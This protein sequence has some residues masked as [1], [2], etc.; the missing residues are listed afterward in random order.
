MIRGKKRGPL[1]SIF[2]FI[3]LIISF[4]NWLFIMFRNGLYRLRLLPR[5]RLEVP[6]I[7]IGNIT[8]GGT[9]KTPLVRLLARKVHDR[10]YT[11]TI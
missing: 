5:R 8:G 9:G 7:S 4:F 3:L 6:V 11:P 10:G 2:L 1:I